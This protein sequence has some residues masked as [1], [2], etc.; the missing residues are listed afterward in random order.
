MYIPEIKTHHLKIVDFPLITVLTQTLGA[1]VP[2]DLPA[3]LADGGPG[4]RA[5]GRRHISGVPRVRSNRINKG[6]KQ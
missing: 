3:D 6:S 5:Q 2:G 1:G 4:A